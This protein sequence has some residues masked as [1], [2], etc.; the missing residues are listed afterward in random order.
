ML[1]ENEFSPIELRWE[2]LEEEE[3]KLFTENVPSSRVSARVR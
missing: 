1:E 2:I 3:D